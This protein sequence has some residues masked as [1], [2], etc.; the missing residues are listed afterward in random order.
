MS[1]KTT[2]ILLVLVAAGAGLVYL[3]EKDAFP[4]KSVPPR[5]EAG[6]RQALEKLKPADLTRIEIRRGDRTTILTRE[7]GIWSMP[8]NWPTRTAEV[9]QL[10]ELLGGLRSRFEAVSLGDNPDLTKYGL[11]KQPVTVKLE[12]D[13]AKYQFVLGEEPEAGGN[14]FSRKTYLRLLS[15]PGVEKPAAEVVRVGPGVIALLDKPAHYYQKRRLFLSEREP[16]EDQPAVKVDQVKADAIYVEEVKT[17]KTD[18]GEKREKVAF[19]LERKNKDWQLAV[20]ESDRLDPERDRLDPARRDALLAALPDLWV[21]RFVDVDHAAVASALS[22]DDSF[23]GALSALG[24]LAMTS[25]EKS[26]QWLKVKTGL[27]LAAPERK[28]TVTRENGAQVTLLIGNVA[29]TGRTLRP[30]PPGVPVPPREEVEEIL[31]AKLEDNSQFFEIKGA[32]LKDIFV[33]PA[34]LRDPRLARFESN[35]ARELE[36]SRPGQEAIQL[37][38]EGDRWK[39]VKPLKAEADAG[40]VTELLSRLSNLQAHGEDV[41]EPGKRDPAAQ[42][43]DKL[44]TTV[45][46]KWETEKTGADGN[47]TKTPGQTTL[48]FGKHDAEKKK[49]YVKTDDWPR[50]NAVE[51]GLAALLDRPALAYRGKRLLDF[52]AADVDRMDVQRG[53]EKLALKQGRDGWKLLAPAESKLDGAKVNRLADALGRLEVLEYVND[54]PMAEQLDAAY[55]VGDSAAV[56]VTVAFRDASKPPQTLRLGK[57]RGTKPGFFGKMADGPAVFAVDELTHSELD[58]D[59]L[60]YLPAELWLLLPEQVAAVRVKKEGQDEFTLKRAGKG[61]A[62]TGPFDAPALPPAAERLVTELAPARCERYKAHDGSKE[63]AKY[64][65]DKPALTVAVT[66]RDGHDRTLLIGKPAE[67]DGPGRYAK[68]ADSSAVCVV[69]DEFIAAVDRPALQLLDPALLRLD[70][71]KVERVTA[72]G[73]EATLTLERKGDGWQVLDTPA[74]EF[75]ADAQAA[76][77]MQSLWANLR[78]TRFDAYGPKVDWAKYGLDKPAVVVTVAVKDGSPKEHT[79]ELG[80]HV[81]GNDGPRYARFDKGQGVPVL[82]VAA[83]Q[84]LARSYLDYVNRNVLQFKADDV[85]K[86]ERRMGAESL[87]VSRNG[88]T[89]QIVM[90]AENRADDKSLQEFVGQLAE[91]RAVRVAAFP[92]KELKTYG[93]DEPAAVVTV[94]LKGDA[95]PAEHVLKIGKP[96]EADGTERYAVVD[97]GKAVVVLDAA[98]SRRL[99]AAPITFRDKALARFADADK[100]RL[101][102][103]PRQ[104]VFARVEGSWKLTEPATADADNDELDEF[105][106]TLARLRADELVAE[107]P[108][109]NELKTYGLDK[110]EAR[111]KLFAGDNEVLSLSVGAREKVGI[112][113]YARLGGKDIVFLLDPKLSTRALAE[114]RKRDVWA[115]PPDASQVESVRFGY[116]KNPF[117]LTKTETGEWQVE[118]K[119]DVRP[120]RAT[121]SE[122]LDALARLKAAR[123]VVDKG[124]DFKL[125]GLEPPELE[126]EITSRTGK[127]TL[128]IG[129]PEGDSKRRYARVTEGGRSDVFV[130]D[131]ADAAKI[132]RDTAAFTKA[133]ERP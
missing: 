19:T 21:V 17:K 29:R 97:D 86:I 83:S 63:L 4:F 82:G 3:G 52:T 95:K 91:L 110:P 59:S 116:A 57:A 65:L 16:K 78:A 119:A 109:A 132:V 69:G 117:V 30:P 108:T 75:V 121:V 88:D 126:V 8:G 72:K 112:R 39:L 9:N 41:V 55:G 2:I 40:K 125:F 47:K 20:Q 1:F 118:G 44:G 105:L 5:A 27:G 64:G 94:K 34:A 133:P 22:R 62:I 103:G 115:A 45:T 123:Y 124:A 76:N 23:G 26:P 122:T 77:S 18:G 11:A 70:P 51:D 15:G 79:V 38:K 37:V 81:E 106:N 53:G 32:G 74:G 60:A 49:L 66:G 24:W 89:W 12:T 107:K 50:V 13:T 46:V 73:G 7:H 96:A 113:R 58:R 98:L 42:G 104:A 131:E 101:E 71:G 54:E 61:W 129:G 93:L 68:L 31:Y 25:P 87:E 14:Q 10:A 33:E 67:K 128:L 99:V 56:V 102:R 114:F 28:I 90:P 130:I 84:T 35:E 43:F 80:K 6:T 85:T 92:A 111:W 100:L 48:K 120:N 36:I 127:R